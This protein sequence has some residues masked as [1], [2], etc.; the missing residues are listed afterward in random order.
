MSVANWFFAFAYIFS[1]VGKFQSDTA[2]YASMTKTDRWAASSYQTFCWYSSVEILNF[3]VHLS[4]GS[5]GFP[6]RVL[7]GGLSSP[8]RSGSLLLFPFERER[9]SERMREWENVVCCASAST[10]DEPRSQIQQRAQLRRYAFHE[11]IY[12]AAIQDTSRIE[13]NKEAI[14]GA[15][16]IHNLRA[17]SDYKII[18]ILSQSCDW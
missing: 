1:W 16:C 13:Q 18:S 9:E 2:S 3:A 12:A 5:S 6:I 7:R 14:A 4:R 8:K 17:R 10:K 11:P 15:N